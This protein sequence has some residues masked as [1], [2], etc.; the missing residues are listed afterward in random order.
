MGGA[1]VESRLSEPGRLVE[2]QHRDEQRRLALHPYPS[3][4]AQ[5]PFFHFPSRNILIYSSF[6]SVL[7]PFRD[8]SIPPALVSTLSPCRGGVGPFIPRLAVVIQIL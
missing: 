4:A 8:G 3:S 2:P 7:F 6:I 5:E 1:R